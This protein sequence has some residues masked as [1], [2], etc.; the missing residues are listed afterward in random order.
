MKPGFCKRQVPSDSLFFKPHLVLQENLLVLL[1]DLIKTLLLIMSVDSLERL[2]GEIALWMEKLAA[3][4]SLRWT[5]GKETTFFCPLLWKV[6]GER[7]C[8]FICQPD[9]EINTCWHFP[10]SP[11]K[12]V[13]VVCRE[14]LGWCL[15]WKISF[16]LTF[17]WLLLCLDNDVVNCLIV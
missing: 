9:F 5:F 17:L 10:F 1:Q 6:G 2:P 8:W 12:I 3:F 7:K 14:T 16:D 4:L 13:S 11:G 15:E